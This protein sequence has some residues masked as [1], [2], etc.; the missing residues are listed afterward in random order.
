MSS[1]QGA[2]STGEEELTLNPPPHE[3]LGLLQL[4]SEEF[5]AH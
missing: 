3:R 4:P 5:E 1:F 2:A